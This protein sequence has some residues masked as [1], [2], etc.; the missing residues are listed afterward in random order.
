MFIQLL[1]FT[2]FALMHFYLK[3]SSFTIDLNLIQELVEINI[4][5]SDN[6]LN[7]HDF[8]KRFL[9]FHEFNIN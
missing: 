7:K 2:F 9:S 8:S 3:W 6:S 5:V 1:L 4:C